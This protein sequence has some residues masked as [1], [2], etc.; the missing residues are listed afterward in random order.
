MAGFGSCH[1]RENSTG[2]GQGLDRHRRVTVKLYGSKP[3]E[4]PG[5]LISLVTED[6]VIRV[7]RAGEIPAGD[8][9]HFATYNQEYP[10]G[11][12]GPVAEKLRNTQTLDI[13][14]KYILGFG[15]DGL[16]GQIDLF[17]ETNE[18]TRQ[19]RKQGRIRGALQALQSRVDFAKLL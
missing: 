8:L 5:M 7:I 4:K 6:G 2:Q 14:G 19:S 1:K 10:G 3:N 12:A 13:D 18:D 11:D 16:Q 15:P 17:P 9:E